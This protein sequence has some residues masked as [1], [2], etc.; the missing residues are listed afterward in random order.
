MTKSEVIR[1]EDIEQMRNLLELSE[2]S[3]INENDVVEIL[4][5]GL[6]SL[7]GR[8]QEIGRAPLY[9]YFEQLGA[10]ECVGKVDAKKIEKVW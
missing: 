4:V 10:G 2:D 5:G 9:S 6:K 7:C 8:I 3:K 1:D